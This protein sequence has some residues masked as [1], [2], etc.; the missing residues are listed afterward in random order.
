MPSHFSIGIGM[1]L[2]VGTYSLGA[3]RA[4]FVIRHNRVFCIATWVKQ[5]LAYFRATFLGV[6]A[7]LPPVRLR[8]RAFEL[9]APR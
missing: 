3:V 9:V 5:G 1:S 4:L 8:V 6:V 2:F 7:L